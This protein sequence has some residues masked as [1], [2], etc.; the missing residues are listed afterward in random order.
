MGKGHVT[1]PNMGR[2][3]RLELVQYVVTEELNGAG[4]ELYPRLLNFRVNLTEFI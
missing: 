1:S 2:E 4:S 3:V